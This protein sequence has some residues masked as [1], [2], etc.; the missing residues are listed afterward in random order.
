MKESML[1]K[2][3]KILASLTIIFLVI[4]TIFNLG[5]IKEVLSYFSI[6]PTQ[7]AGVSIGACTVGA[8]FTDYCSGALSPTLSWAIT[9]GTQTGYAVQV[10]ND[11]GPLCDS[12]FPSPEVDTGLVISDSTSYV[13]PGGLLS[14]GT[15][16][17]WQVAVRG[18]SSAWTGWI[19]H[20]ESFTTP[21]HQWP[22]VDFSWDPDSPRAEAEVQFIDG[23]SV[24]GG[25][26][27][28]EWSWTFEDGTPATSSE[29][30]PIVF[31]TSEGDKQVT[32]QVTDS[33]GYVCSE[34]KTVTI[35]ASLIKFEEI[36][37]R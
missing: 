9:D 12:P 16:Y 31:F 34:S 21:L 3:L 28:Q 7:E 2:N 10:D 18:G 30:N 23:S 26:T 15:T 14:Y 17:Y 37:P 5:E 36:I 11:G 8:T 33:D 27:K 32:L 19:P 25:A 20:D 24:Y 22:S 35:G 29:Q 4:I 6:L 1:K 13:V